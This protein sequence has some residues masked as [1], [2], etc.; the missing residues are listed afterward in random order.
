MGNRV[1]RFLTCLSVAALAVLPA[2][3][4]GGQAAAEA[5]DTRSEESH[6]TESAALALGWSSIGGPYLA[7]TPQVLP[8]EDLLFLLGLDASA[9]AQV[10]ENGMWSDPI[11]L[12]GFFNSAVVP[13][14]AL[15]PLPFVEAFGVGLDDAMWYGTEA[16]GWQSLGGLFIFD[17]VAVTVQGVTYVFG[18]GQDHALWYRSVTSGWI[19]L[20]GFLD[21]TP[22]ATTDGTNLYIS[23]VG[24]DGALW[25]R[26]LSP[27]LTWS[28]WQSHG[29]FVVSYAA[30]AF[31]NNAGYLFAIGGDDAVWYLRVSGGTWSG[32]QSLGG[33]AFTAPA[34]TA[35]FN[36]GVDVFVVGQDS[37]MYQQRLTSGG[38]SGWQHLGGQFISAPS[39][40]YS[41]VFGIG[42]DSNLWAA[43]YL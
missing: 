30:S 19:S 2:M 10:P 34:A 42:L 27:S 15:N 17:P 6:A 20:G 9:Y 14:L 23:G 36:G 24:G 16:T 39:A 1:R 43:G 25:T 11:S 7:A 31:L 40:S 4:I 13:A 35:D 28:P 3:W 38:W 33:I 8:P 26:Q 41:E 22:E 21:S 32:W 37:A 12:G 29:G 5:N 18:V